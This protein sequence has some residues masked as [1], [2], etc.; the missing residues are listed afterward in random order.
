MR[1]T[2]G[3]AVALALAATA[4]GCG[5][6]SAQ[7]AT[8]PAVT[9]P[10]PQPADPEPVRLG[11]GDCAGDTATFVTGPR[12]A[13]FEREAVAA[14]MASLP[15]APEGSDAGS[16]EQVARSAGIIGH[17]ETTEGGAFSTLTGTG[18]AD[19]YGGLLGDEVGEMQGGFGVGTS[20]T[21]PDG[22]GTG[23][24]TIGTG[25]YGTIGHG[26]GNG[27]M[28]GRKV[29]P[30]VNIGNAT[31]TG[32]LDRN[33]IRRY[34]RRTLP[35][36]RYCYEK[37][38]VAK[39]SLA[40]TVT[41]EFTIGIDGE[42]AASKAAGMDAVV[43]TCI[44]DAIKGIRFPKPRGGGVV[45]V[46]YPFTFRVASAD[47]DESGRDD[48]PPTVPV[49]PAEQLEEAQPEQPKPQPEQPQVERQPQK[50]QVEGQSQPEQPET[51]PEADADAPAAYVA[52]EDNPLRAHAAAIEKCLRG[53]A[54]GAGVVELRLDADGA[55]SSTAGFGFGD[56]TTAACVAEAAR[57]VRWP[58]GAGVIH[59]C[60]LSYGTRAPGAARGVDITEAAID[61]DGER[62][63]DLTTYHPEADGDHLV[64]PLYT[65]L[66][67]EQRR[68]AYQPESVVVELGPLVVRP[69]DATP[70]AWVYRVTESLDAAE[71]YWLLAVRDGDA[72]RLLRSVTLPVVPVPLG[73]GDAWD[74]PISAVRHAR[75]TGRTVSIEVSLDA[76]K[77]A[78][79]SGEVTA[80]PHAGGALD[81]DRLR[82][83]LDRHKQADVPDRRRI[84][85]SGADEVPYRQV[86]GA[87]ETAQHAGFTDWTLVRPPPP[88]R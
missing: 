82:A 2:L 43:A 19:V 67:A 54:P 65:P 72:W 23:W 16:D 73:T 46:R 8:T 69:V 11:F 7:P 35:Q 13:A 49:E 37:E 29:T 59:R 28:R 42:V 56:S 41:A 51:P 55:P 9:E 44:A 77:V 85:I 84:Q 70:M 78:L 87:I 57:A 80:I 36:I 68:L 50:P 45:H 74:D 63:V 24:G 33:I 48:E 83:V 25:R 40:G 62:V 26:S 53:R 20:G 75:G 71:A 52:G 61:L 47:E 22:G 79:S 76:V 64:R 15:P 38:L 1:T 39:P 66:R 18:D 60:S 5:D 31:A 86:A 17:L 58:E 81:H 27:G 34:I 88:A 32:D 21:G 10:A 30:S 3:G 12:P 6:R 14:H 4:P